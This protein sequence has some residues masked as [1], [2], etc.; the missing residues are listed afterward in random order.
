M[1][2]YRLLPVIL[3]LLSFVFTA[4]DKDDD[5]PPAPTKTDLLTSSTWK[6]VGVYYMNQDVSK[7]FADNGYDIQK[8]SIKFD[9]SG[10]Y[11]E[12]YDGQNTSGKWEFANNEQALLLNRGTSDEFNLRLLK[13]DDKNLYIE[14][15]FKDSDGT[16]Y[17]LE[18]RFVH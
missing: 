2:T 11:T 17:I 14:Y 18:E 12:T 9:K 13:L 6:G 8:Y 16:E 5:T 10:N 4:C 15:T 1:Q 7:I 3:L